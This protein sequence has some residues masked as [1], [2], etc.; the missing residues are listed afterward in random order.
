MAAVVSSPELSASPVNVS[1]RELATLAQYNGAMGYPNLDRSLVLLGLFLLPLV[2]ADAGASAT[3]DGLAWVAPFPCEIRGAQLG[4]VASAG[5]TGT[6]DVHKAEAA[7]PTTYAS[8][9]TA[10]TDTKTGLGVMQTASLDDTKITLAQ[11]DRLRLRS[12]SGAGGS[13]TGNQGLLWIKRL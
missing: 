13:L 2:G 7:T 3:G 4:S 8:V 1:D 11:G 6:L 5:A 10:A 12:A 9:Q